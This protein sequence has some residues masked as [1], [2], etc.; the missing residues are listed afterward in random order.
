MTESEYIC[1]VA[2]C[3]EA[4]LIVDSNCFCSIKEDVIAYEALNF[5]EDYLTEEAITFLTQNYT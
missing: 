5:E 2:K 1:L 4:E 3:A